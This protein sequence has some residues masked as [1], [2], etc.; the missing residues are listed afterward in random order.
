MPRDCCRTRCG[1][2][3]YDTTSGHQG[4]SRCKQL[5]D[6]SFSRTRAEVQNQKL[7]GTYLKRFLVIMS[8]AGEIT[9]M[10]RC[11]T[12]MK[13]GTWKPIR[14]AASENPSLCSCVMATDCI[15]RTRGAWSS[16]NACTS[17]GTGASFGMTC[18]CRGAAGLRSRITMSS[19]SSN[20]INFPF[21]PE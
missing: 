14:A 8:A 9:C 12:E 17:R 7:P 16:V 6:S 4:H 13:G 21:A 18:R 19:S 20:K 11:G 3:R 1:T 15:R 5:S 10:C 2:Q